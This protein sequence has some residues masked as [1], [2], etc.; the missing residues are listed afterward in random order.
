[1]SLDCL[2]TCPVKLLSAK[3][4][5]RPSQCTSLSQ[6]S[7]EAPAQ[8]L[9]V[10]R[11]IWTFGGPQTLKI[12]MARNT[13]SASRMTTCDGPAWVSWAE[14]QKHLC[15]IR[16]MKPGWTR[17]MWPNSSICKWTTVANIYH[18]ILTLTSRPMAL[19][20]AS[21]CTTH[22]RRMAY[23][24]TLI[25]PCWSMHAQCTFLRTCPNFYGP[26]LCNTQHG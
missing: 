19:Y 1:M 5:P 11:S 21:L 9:M 15:A 8:Q 7:M 3:H 13:S 2:W 4:E 6:R 10:K 12:W 18:M 24:N 25:I 16:P 17:N 23:M 26:N 20:A 14:N 22:L